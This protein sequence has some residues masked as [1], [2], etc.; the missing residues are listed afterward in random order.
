MAAQRGWPITR[1]WPLARCVVAVASWGQGALQ[2]SPGTRRCGRGTPRMRRSTSAA[3]PRADRHQHGA[4]PL[5]RETSV[6]GV[7][8]RTATYDDVAGPSAIAG[9]GGRGRAGGLRVDAGTVNGHHRPG[10]YDCNA[11]QSTSSPI[12]PPLALPRL[13]APSEPARGIRCLGNIGE[14]FFHCAHARWTMTCPVTV[15]DVGHCSRSRDGKRAD[16]VLAW[17]GAN[18]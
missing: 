14:R 4:Q 16:D 7:T 8:R 11:D 5:E 3:V 13:A 1:R 15:L 12:A 17:L 2:R 9:S 10:P 6:I 18:V